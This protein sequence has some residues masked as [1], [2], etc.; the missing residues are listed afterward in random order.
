MTRNAFAKVSIATVALA[1]A[2]A[3]PTL[4]TAQSYGQPYGQA[5]GQPYGGTYGGYDQRGYANYDTCSGREQEGRVGGAVIGATI[6]AIAGSQVAARGRRTEGSILGGVLGA[7]I[8]AGVGSD[9]NRCNTGYDQ[10]GTTY[11]QGYGYNTRRDD[12]RYDGYDR[13]DRSYGYDSGQYRDSYGYDRNGCR[14][15]ETRDRDRRGR[16]VTRYEQVCRQGY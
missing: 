14:T 11:G 2:V 4:A 6:G 7:V 10:R 13:D 16:E 5:Y 15:V 9:A 3:A 12:Y 1:A 8:G